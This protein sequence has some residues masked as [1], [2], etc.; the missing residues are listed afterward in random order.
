[1]HLIRV[2]NLKGEQQ[3]HRFNTLLAAVN[4]VA[5]EQVGCL[6]RRPSLVKEPQEIVIL[7]VNVS[8][9]DQGCLKSK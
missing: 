3:A 2:L 6:W 9:N 8:T 5:Q 4:V 1:M 7:P